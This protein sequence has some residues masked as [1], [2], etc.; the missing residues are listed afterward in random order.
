M[1]TVLTKFITYI[2]EI[3]NYYYIISHIFLQIIPSLV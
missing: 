3:Y 1:Q 2:T